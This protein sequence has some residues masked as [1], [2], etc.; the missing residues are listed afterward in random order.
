VVI[1]VL[2]R[3]AGHLQRVLSALQ[4]D[5]GVDFAVYR[6]EALRRAAADVD[7]V[8][9]G[10]DADARRRFVVALTAEPPMF[11]EPA[12]WRALREHVVPLLKTYPSILAWVPACGTGETAYAL[13][14]LLEDAGLLGRTRIYAT[15]AHGEALDVARSGALS[16]D[17]FAAAAAGCE[18]TGA[19]MP[20]A[21]LFASYT[22]EHVVRDDVKARIVFA[23]HNVAT[24]A[25][26]NEFQLVVHGKGLARLAPAVAARAHELVRES[27]AISGVVVQ[28]VPATV[29]LDT[30][31][32]FERLDPSFPIFRKRA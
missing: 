6:D 3:P 27:L 28:T 30:D 14:A 26:L 2:E 9:P 16:L 15:D 13:A 12:L 7:V 11:A 31:G 25:S 32:G 22:H 23:E 19:T 10:I 1:D 21:R 5:T 8:E 18:A 4:S 29:D 17:V 20:L 24:D